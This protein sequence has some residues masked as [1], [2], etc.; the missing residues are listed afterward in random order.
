MATFFLNAKDYGILYI[1]LSY[2]YMHTHIYRK[3]YLI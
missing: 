1:T 3:I 2:I